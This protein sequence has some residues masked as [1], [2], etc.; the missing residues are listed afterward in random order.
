MFY[1]ETGEW[2]PPSGTS[3]ALSEANWGK[4][5]PEMG[6]WV[7]AVIKQVLKFS[8]SKWDDILERADEMRRARG[9]AY[10]KKPKVVAEVNEEADEYE[11]VGSD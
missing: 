11:M 5:A 7:S 4:T 6:P 2:N 3:A 1:S 10:K 8:K 9:K